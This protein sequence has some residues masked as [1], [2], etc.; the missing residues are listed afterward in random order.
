LD[1][2]FKIIACIFNHIVAQYNLWY[3]LKLVETISWSIGSTNY[4]RRSYVVGG[5]WDINDPAFEPLNQE[6]SKDSGV[7]LTVAVD[8]V[9]KVVS[10]CSFIKRVI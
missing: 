5:I 3:L 6:T 10:S 1:L 8:L 4:G 9:I 2:F 7:F